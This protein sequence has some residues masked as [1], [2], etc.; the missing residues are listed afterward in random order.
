M[1]LWKYLCD[2][3]KKSPAQTI[4]EG[5]AVLTY[6]EL[7]IFAKA[8]SEQLK[9]ELCC[10]IYCKSEL[11]AAMAIMSCFAAEV[12]AVPI[13]LRYGEAHCKKIIDTIGPTCIIT[14]FDGELR[15][16]HITDSEFIPPKIRPALIMCTSGTTGTP[17]GAMISEENIITNVEDIVKYL[18]MDKTDTILISRPIYHCAVLTGEF[19][20]A[21]INGVKIE[22]SSDYFEP[23]QILELLCEKKITVFGGTPTLLA[24]LARFTR[25]RD[26]IVLKHI[27][28]S[29]ECMSA[30]VGTKIAD[31]FGQANI[32]HVYGLTEA[33][34][35]VSYMPPEFFREAPDRVGVPLA[36]VK[37]KILGEDGNIV[38]VGQRGILYVKG[39]NVMMG[40]YN[41]LELTRAVLSDGWLCTNDIASVDE[42]GWLKIYGR[43]DDL[44][45]RAGMNIYP[46]EI[47]AEMKKDPRTTDVLVYNAGNEKQGAQIG[48][49]I[50]GAF[51][52]KRDVHELCMKLLPP[53]QI[54]TTINLLESL[55][56]NGSGK[57]IRRK[58]NDR[59]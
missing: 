40:Y 50:C 36:S 51:K 7:I 14:D 29:G 12:T 27:I 56:K 28:I 10:A 49:D 33:S 17:K 23:T 55:E 25:A 53:Y 44:I 31:A 37:I 21:L 47:E 26:G 41:A 8:F 34:P 18:G 20:C 15:V 52:D 43:S 2:N 46:Q 22:F 57:I 42:N 6:E 1:R 16:Y 19:I 11:A 13:S 3:M 54:P 38:G 35:R 45:I 48:M 59:A 24:M 9:G 4:S 5:D 30:E 58:N 32:Y 39:G